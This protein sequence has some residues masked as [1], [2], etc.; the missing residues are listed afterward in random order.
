LL[1]PTLTG[2]SA[3]DPGGLAVA[4][5]HAPLVIMNSAKTINSAHPDIAG[6]KY[7]LLFMFIL[8]II[9]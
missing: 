5:F 2:A 3:F 7:F 6:K 8:L 1:A 9:F 4:G